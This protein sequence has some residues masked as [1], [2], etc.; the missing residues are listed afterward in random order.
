MFNHSVP[1][2]LCGLYLPHMIEAPLS[3]VSITNKIFAFTRIGVHKD[4]RF[5]HSF[6]PLIAEGKRRLPM[7]MY[8]EEMGVLCTRETG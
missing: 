4:S 7:C 5:C 8:C 2:D 3:H 1:L 6:G